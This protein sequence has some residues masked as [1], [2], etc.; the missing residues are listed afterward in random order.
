MPPAYRSGM[1]GIFY[2][3]RSNFRI[4]IDIQRISMSNFIVLKCIF[5]NQLQT[6]RRNPPVYRCQIIGQVQIQLFPETYF[7]E[8]IIVRINSTSS[9]NL[10]RFSFRFSSTV[11]KNADPWNSCN[12]WFAGILGRHSDQLGYSRPV[13]EL[14]KSVRR[15]SHSAG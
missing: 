15:W 5:E 10:L 2:N 12:N 14:T 9:S 11:E 6:H 13:T 3:H 4:N 7:L 1:I 8:K